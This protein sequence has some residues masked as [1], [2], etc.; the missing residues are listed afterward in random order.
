MDTRAGKIATKLIETLARPTKVERTT[1]ASTVISEH[2]FGFKTFNEPIL[3]RMLDAAATFC[4]DMKDDRPPYWLTL[5]GASATGKT[6]LAKSISKY[7]T[8]RIYGRQFMPRFNHVECCYGKSWNWTAVVDRLR[9]QEYHATEALKE[10]WFCCIDDIGAERD[11]TK[12]AAERLLDVLNH[13]RDKWTV[14]TTNLML[15]D[16]ATAL[17]TRIASRLLRD[18]SKVIQ[19]NAKDYNLR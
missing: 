10:D 3:S 1:T 18:G 12:F 2:D 14:L 9:G 17:D 6:H 11:P 7:F 4:A 15:N 5:C 16:I 13:R 19:S 8:K